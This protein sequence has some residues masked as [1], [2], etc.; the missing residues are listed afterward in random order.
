MKSDYRTNHVIS[1]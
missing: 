1:N